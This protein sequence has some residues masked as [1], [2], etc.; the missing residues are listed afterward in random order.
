MLNLGSTE[1]WLRVAAYRLLCAVKE[2]FKLELD[3]HLDD[4][5]GIQINY[6]KRSIHFYVIVRTF[7]DVCIPMNST[8]FVLDVS[9]QLAVKES[10]LTLEVLYP[11]L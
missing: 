5:H 7:I 6:F 8:S 1:P 11:L 9:K 3:I 4:S 10:H 2:T